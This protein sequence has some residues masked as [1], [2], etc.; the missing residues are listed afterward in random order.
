M[1]D[2]SS[3]LPRPLPRAPIC[4]YTTCEWEG[5]CSPQI[6]HNNP[7]ISESEYRSTSPTSSTARASERRSTR[8]MEGNEKGKIMASHIYMDEI[9]N[10]IIRK[11]FFGMCLADPSVSN[12][13]Q[14]ARSLRSALFFFLRS[15][16]PK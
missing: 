5:V 6:Y 13:P 9:C 16:F 10:K 15:A 11:Y 1:L 12:H 4:R 3:P 14:Q 2:S 7:S 8:G